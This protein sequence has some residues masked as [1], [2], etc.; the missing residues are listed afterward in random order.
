LRFAERLTDAREAM[1]DAVEN[2]AADVD[3]SAAA[4][5][6]GPTQ[7][8]E[9]LH[10]QR[11]RS[12][13]TMPALDR[14][15]GVLYDALDARSLTP[16]ARSFAAEHVAVHA[17]LLGPVGALDP[18]PAYRLSHDSRV[19]GLPLKAHWRG[20]VS[21]ALHSQDGLVLD[22]RSE[23]YVALGPAPAGSFY[24]RVLTEES[25]GARRAL[26]HFNKKAKGEFTRSLVQAKVDHPTVTAL[27]RWAKRRGWR[28]EQQGEH[29]L[30]LIV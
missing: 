2:L 11:L 10:N 21:D 1:L 14:Y 6:L 28:L 19:P 7:R 9:V 26:N 8:D 13:A 23:G 29:E 15:T 17:A 5:K 20:P 16:L 18:I 30:A 4:L 25:N 12:S 24:V 27:L 22:L 3:A